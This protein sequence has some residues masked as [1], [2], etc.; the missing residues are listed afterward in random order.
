MSDVLLFEKR[1]DFHKW[2]L[3]NV[4]SSKGVWLVFSKKKEVQTLSAHEA[5]EEALCFGWIDGQMKS[6]DDTYY[7]KYFA[8]RLANSKWSEKNKKLA[9]ELDKKGLVTKYGK[10][11]IAEAKENGQWKKSNVIVVNEEDIQFIE[12]LLK[13]HEQAYKNFMAMS[14]SVRK[15]YT[16]AYVQT[17]SDEGKAKRLVWMVDRLNQNLKPM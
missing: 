12:E 8:R 7:H 2:L 11:K 9:Q 13:P 17:K 3:E 14:N 6:I 10:E 5:L 16:K 1:E 4:E 15:T